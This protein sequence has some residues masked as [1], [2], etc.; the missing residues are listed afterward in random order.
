MSANKQNRSRRINETTLTDTYWVCG[1]GQWLCL[2]ENLGKARV[3]MSELR[4]R[5]KISD[6]ARL[7][8]RTTTMKGSLYGGLTIEQL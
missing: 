4:R 3:A 7:E 2:G 1:I 6:H 8:R 5:G